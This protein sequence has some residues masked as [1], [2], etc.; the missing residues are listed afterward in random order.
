MATPPT[1]F[2]ATPAN[3][4]VALTWDAQA[5]C[6]FL[7]FRKPTY[8][9]DGVTPTSSAWYLQ[10]WSGTANSRTDGPVASATSFDY[11]IKA[12]DGGGTS[13][14]SE[15]TAVTPSAA[16]SGP[17]YA[18]DTAFNVKD[19]VLK[20]SGSPVSYPVSPVTTANTGGDTAVVAD[21]TQ[22][23]KLNPT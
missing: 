11:G 13:A 19:P 7:L 18:L 10:V 5:G 21:V 17:P 20:V 3:M 15:L 6:T 9:P 8:Q 2:S 1:S 23:A 14:Y 16:G 4:R 22:R 12:R